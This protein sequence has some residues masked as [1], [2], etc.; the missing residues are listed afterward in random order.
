MSGGMKILQMEDVDMTRL[1]TATTHLG[2]TNVNY[3]MAQY[4]FKRRPDG[5]ILVETAPLAI[6]K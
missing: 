6:V 5:E 3:Q 1:L 4:V 2:S